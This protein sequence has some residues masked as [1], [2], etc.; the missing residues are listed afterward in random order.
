MASYCSQAARDEGE[1]LGA[2]AELLDDAR[3]ADARVADEL[4]EAAEAHAHRHERRVEHGQLALAVDERQ[5]LRR[6]ALPCAG[7]VADRD[8]LD[9][10]RLPFQRQRSDRLRGEERARAVEELRRRPDRARLG[11]GHQPCGQR[12]RAAED[13]ERL[14]VRR[15]DAAGEDVPGR[16]S[17]VQRQAGAGVDRGAHGAKQAL[18]VLAGGGRHAGHEDDP[19]A[20]GVDVA[21]EEADAVRG[22][23]VLQGV[24][25]LLDR[26]GVQRL[27]GSAE[28]DEGDRGPAMF[29]LDRLRDEMRAQL[30]G[31]AAEDVQVGRVAAVRRCR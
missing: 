26:V 31:D 3:L 30:L 23:R 11:L 24:D 7:H 15:P 9:R 2:V 27:R 28:A 20:G 13:R 21:L 1:S 17:D 19:S 10:L 22:G 4:D 29:A 5:L 12:G 16:D 14:A 18:L 25:H 6:L 8:R